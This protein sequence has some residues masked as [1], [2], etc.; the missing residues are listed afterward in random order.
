MSEVDPGAG[1]GADHGL[2]E[3]ASGPA[4]RS[5]VVRVELSHLVSD[6]E[7]RMD[8]AEGGCPRLHELRPEVSTSAS[9]RPEVGL[10][11]PGPDVWTSALTAMAVLK[12]CGYDAC[13]LHVV[14]QDQ[15]ERHRAA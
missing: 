7:I 5:Y 13:A 4:A 15:G 3:R 14:T 12:Q 11:L 6:E 2:P 8:L 1:V 10:V 9:G